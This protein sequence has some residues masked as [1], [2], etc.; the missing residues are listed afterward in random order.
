MRDVCNIAA[1]GIAHRILAN[2]QGI[3][4]TT[5]VNITS[6]GANNDNN[7]SHRSE[8]KASL[9]ELPTTNTL[10]IIYRTR[11]NDLPQIPIGSMPARPPTL[12]AAPVLGGH[13]RVVR[14]GGLLR[15][16]TH[17]AARPHRRASFTKSHQM[18]KVT[19]K[20]RSD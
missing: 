7:Q 12:R 9:I 8:S 3:E 18:V 19:R 14:G 6:A 20:Y 15:S 16:Y 11:T 13:L 10:L 5:F 4:V 2:L 17:T 1:S